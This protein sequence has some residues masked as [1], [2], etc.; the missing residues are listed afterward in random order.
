[1][2]MKGILQLLLIDWKPRKFIVLEACVLF[3]LVCTQ[4]QCQG[5]VYHN[6]L[7]LESIKIGRQ[8]RNINSFPEDKIKVLIVLISDVMS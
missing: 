5:I 8:V 1:M 6:S 2:V 4:N 3:E 7:Q